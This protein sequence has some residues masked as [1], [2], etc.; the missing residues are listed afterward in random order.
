M[1]VY[2]YDV[3]VNDFMCYIIIGI[4]Q[5]V[6]VSD[7]NLVFGEDVFFFVFKCVLIGIKMGRNG[8]RFLWVSV[9]IF[10]QYKVRVQIVYR[11]IFIV[12]MMVF[13]CCF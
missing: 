3:F 10:G 4:R 13:S 9:K 1:I 5:F 2:Q 6:V 8:L 12:R 11:D 7:V